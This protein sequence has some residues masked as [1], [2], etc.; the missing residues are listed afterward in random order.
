MYSPGIPRAYKMNRRRH[1]SWEDDSRDSCCKGNSAPGPRFKVS[2]YHV[3]TARS[4][5]TKVLHLSF[6]FWFLFKGNIFLATSQDPL[7]IVWGIT[8]KHLEGVKHSIRIRDYPH[9]LPDAKYSNT[10]ASKSAILLL[11]LRTRWNAMHNSITSPQ[12]DF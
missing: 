11:I 5:D 2:L 7:R 6:I 8:Q 1:S 4:T 9:M 10:K 3:I 12:I